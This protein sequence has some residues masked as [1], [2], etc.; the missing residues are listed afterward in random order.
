MAP[1]DFKPGFFNTLQH[2]LEKFHQKLR[3]TAKSQK[4]IISNERGDSFFVIFGRP[5]QSHFLSV[6]FYHDLSSTRIIP[7]S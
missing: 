3:L 5:I 4:E 2:K 6:E 1:K 7:K